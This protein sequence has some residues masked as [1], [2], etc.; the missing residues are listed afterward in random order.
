MR[1]ASLAMQRPARPGWVAAALIGSLLTIG[2]CA[3]QN[4]LIV[5]VS[6]VGDRTPPDVGDDLDPQHLDV[7]AYTTQKP[8]FYA[9][10]DPD[11]WLFVWKDPRPDAKPPPTP[12]SVD[13]ESQMIFVATSDAPDAQGMEISRVVRT[14][15]GVHVYVKETLAG[16]GCTTPPRKA[17]PMD[18]VAFAST[19]EDIHVHEDRERA[20]PCG[21]PPQAVVECRIAGSGGAGVNKLTA[22]PGQKISCNSRKSRARTGG[23]VDRNWFLRSAPP[24][25]TSG[26]TI[27]RAGLGTTLT[28]DAWGPYT[29]RLEV[30]DETGRIGSAEA[31]VSVP[32][33]GDSFP[34]QLGWTADPKDDPTTFPR[35]EL[36]VVELPAKLGSA[37]DC[38][39]DAPHDPWCTVA[40]SVA[41][42]QARLKPEPRKRY[43]VA[44]KYVDDRFAGAPVACVRTFP[45]G[46]P[47]FQ[48]CEDAATVRKAGAVWDLG[49]LDPDTG[50]FYDAKLP[51]PPA[52]PPPPPP[53]A[54]TGTAA[55][56]KTPAAPEATAAPKTPPHR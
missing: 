45:P 14:S 25:S 50:T 5:H 13:L 48:T 17:P 21:P 12:R 31:R 19:D 41:L 39:A 22:S 54:A 8:G 34:I 4:R 38:T 1:Y 37:D 46:K 20:D 51:K 11:Q 6:R 18:M 56:P 29:L 42:Q 15:T 32:P 28:V 27:G 10:H 40:S 2:A 53:P 23:I 49:A 9:V 43:R 7:G 16:E 47:P 33:P 3:T 35:F 30:S 52:P 55:A 44:V 36:H 26:L 24:G